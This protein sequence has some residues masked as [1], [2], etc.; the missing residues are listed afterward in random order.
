MT[1]IVNE[2]TPNISLP[3]EVDYMMFDDNINLEILNSLTPFL[4]ILL[5]YEQ[6]ILFLSQMDNSTLVYINCL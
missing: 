4:K 5:E 2:S 6:S 3:G 1:S